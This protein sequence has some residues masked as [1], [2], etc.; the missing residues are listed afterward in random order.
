MEEQEKVEN[1]VLRKRFL[2]FVEDKVRKCRSR[3]G[4]VTCTDGASN[5]QHVGDFLKGDFQGRKHRYPNP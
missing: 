2:S 5:L 1:C 3:R 4:S